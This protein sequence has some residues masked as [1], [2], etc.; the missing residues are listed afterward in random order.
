MEVKPDPAVLLSLIT[1]KMPY[2]KYK[3]RLICDIPEHYLLWCKSKDAWPKGKLGDLLKN[4]FEIK[5]NGLDYL[6]AELKSIHNS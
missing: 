5:E 4:V 6:F 1:T 3:G 2:G